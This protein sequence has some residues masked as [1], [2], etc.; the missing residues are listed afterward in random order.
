MAESSGGK[1]TKRALSDPMTQ[2]TMAE[3]P[4][5]RLQQVVEELLTEVQMQEFFKRAHPE[6]DLPMLPVLQRWRD[7]LMPIL[8][9]V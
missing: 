9:E 7:L 3:Q 1:L 2:P 8:D 6:A 5:M 4:R